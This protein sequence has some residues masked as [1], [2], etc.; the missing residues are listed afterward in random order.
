MKNK[1]GDVDD[2]NR[3]IRTK[4]KE[5]PTTADRPLIESSLEEPFIQKRKKE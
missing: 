1:Q 3:E 5:D 4:R 2:Q